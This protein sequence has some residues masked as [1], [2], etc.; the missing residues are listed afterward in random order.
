MS[1]KNLTLVLVLIVFTSSFAFAVDPGP[2]TPGTIT[3]KNWT[4][5]ET[6]N[7]VLPTGTYDEY[8]DPIPSFVN[9]FSTITYS[10]DADI[11]DG[12]IPL[13]RYNEFMQVFIAGAPSS[14]MPWYE[15][16]IRDD[17]AVTSKAGSVSWGGWDGTRYIKWRFGANLISSEVPGH[18]QFWDNFQATYF[19]DWE[20]VL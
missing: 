17:L 7:Y 15:Q 13:D 4:W 5:S 14:L 10:G 2:E 16:S 19:F 1:F 18:H 6:Q 20:S 11:K 3:V 9:I 8:S 12:F